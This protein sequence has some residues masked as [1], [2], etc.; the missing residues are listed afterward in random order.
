M[1]AFLQNF[2]LTLNTVLLVFGVGVALVVGWSLLR[3]ALKLAM[4]PFRI[5]CAV[6]VVILVAI[7]LFNALGGG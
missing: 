3:S 7:L 4:A 5:G 2:G 1:D 6:I